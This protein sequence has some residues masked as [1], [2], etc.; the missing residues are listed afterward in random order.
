MNKLEENR[1]VQEICQRLD[2]SIEHLDPSI[3]ARLDSSR[4]DALQSKLQSIDKEADSLAQKVRRELNDNTGVSA[5][6]EARLDQIRQQAIA[7]L[8]TAELRGAPSLVAQIRDWFESRFSTF[9]LPVP[10][11]V[12]RTMLATACVLVTVVSIFY[13]NFR[14]TGSLSLEEE[15]S[16]VASAEDIE[17]YENL[18]FYLWLAENESLTL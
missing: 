18:D 3:S 13:V 12:P 17:L 10:G 6:I 1:F 15:I 8:D 16:L 2:A 9:S 11:T 5:E 4:Q 7:R 14:P